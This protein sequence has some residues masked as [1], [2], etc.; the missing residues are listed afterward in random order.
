MHCFLTCFFPFLFF[1]K[2]NKQ[3]K[4]LLPKTLFY[5]KNGSF[6]LK[7]KIRS[8]SSPNDIFYYLLL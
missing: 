4:L 6:T 8:N 1:K 2:K 7:K 3:L 5:I